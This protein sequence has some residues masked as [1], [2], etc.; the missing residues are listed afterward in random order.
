MKKKKKKAIFLGLVLI[1]GILALGFF[2]LNK[3]TLKPSSQEVSSPSTT[4]SPAPSLPPSKNL[5]GFD[6]EDKK[7]GILGGQH[8]LT[9][10]KFGQ[11]EGYERVTIS[12]TASSETS[13]IPFYQTHLYNN[14]A[15]PFYDLKG[16][17]ISKN[18]GT[19]RIEVW[20]SDTRDYSLEA[21]VPRKTYQGEE[22]ITPSGQVVS[23]ILLFHPAD[24]NSLVILVGLLKKS[25]YKVFTLKNPLRLV[26]DVQI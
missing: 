4:L 14:E 18:L 25:P 15:K 1:A 21:E 8:Y 13:E 23:K 3:K 24:D 17:D 20:L 5:E 19:E 7:G 26:I 9:E 6:L 2:L 10:I 11:H 16:N 22:L 12:F